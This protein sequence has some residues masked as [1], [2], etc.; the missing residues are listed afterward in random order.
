M[1]RFLLPLLSLPLAAAAC[2]QQAEPEVLDAEQAIAHALCRAKPLTQFNTAGDEGRLVFSPDGKHAMW[3]RES[4]SYGIEI[5][6]SRLVGGTWTAAQRVPFASPYT[7]FD[8]FIALDGRTVYYTTFRPT[9]GTEQRPDGDIWMTR[10]IN[11]AYTTPVR[12][13]ANINTDANEFF[14]SQTLDGTLLWNSDREDNVGAWD[15]WR[16][17]NITSASAEL[18]PGDLNTDIWEFNPSPTPF[19]T[20]L[21]FG[22]LDPDPLAPYS[23]VFFSLRLHGQYTAGINAG[24]CINTELEEYHPTI[25]WARGRLIFV[26]RN[27][28]T[29]GDFYEAPL[30]A[31]LLS[32]L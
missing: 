27:L 14:P 10:F 2:T 8:P 12:L 30:P 32:L 11:G 28:E 25:D 24:P 16:T 6:E 26:R 21:A 18:V 19:G 7:E 31:A 5:V 13:G 17:R 9:S 22:S 20:L 1:K 15:L 3:H 4:A 23:D 29:N